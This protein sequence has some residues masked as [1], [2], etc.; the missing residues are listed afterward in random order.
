MPFRGAVGLKFG[1]GARRHPIKQD[2]RL[3]QASTRQDATAK[4]AEVG[5]K[6]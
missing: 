5:M 1:S 4:D 3:R 6:K 2:F